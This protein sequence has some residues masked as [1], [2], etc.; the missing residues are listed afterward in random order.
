MFGE[1]CGGLTHTEYTYQFLEMIDNQVFG[2]KNANWFEI[3]QNKQIPLAAM[4]FR[5]DPYAWV[6]GVTIPTSF[7]IPLK[8]LTSQNNQI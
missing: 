3:C 6:K 1:H 8:A 5:N 4:T 7:K 2:R